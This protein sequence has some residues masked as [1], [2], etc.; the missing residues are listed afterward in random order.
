[1]VKNPP[2]S[3]QDTRVI[4]SMPGLKR[5]REVKKWQPT[6]VF[7]PGRFH[8]QTTAWRATVHRAAKSWT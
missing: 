8:G 4:D 1:M 7:L 5:S 3:A 6:S 2:A